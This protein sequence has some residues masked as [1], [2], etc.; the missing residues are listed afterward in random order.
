MNNQEFNT[1]ITFYEIEQIDFNTK[2]SDVEIEETVLFLHSN[3]ANHSL[4]TEENEINESNLDKRL[5]SINW[6]KIVCKKLKI[7][8]QTFLIAQKVFDQVFNTLD[9]NIPED[10]ILLL[11]VCSL[12][13]SDKFE[14]ISFFG[15]EI[16]FQRLAKQ[17]FSINKLIQT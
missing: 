15:Y 3:V 11:A 1:L 7:S 8:N 2:H 16:A 9:H 6:M 5:F 12:I 17:K 4:L 10:D 14:E 13:I